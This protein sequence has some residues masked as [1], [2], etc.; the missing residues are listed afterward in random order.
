MLF[1]T[2]ASMKVVAF[3]KLQDLVNLI[4]MK[5]LILVF[6]AT[7]FWLNKTS[8]CIVGM[9]QSMASEAFIH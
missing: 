6:D 7:G 8:F 3:N 9:E 2:A 1:A 5:T 4:N